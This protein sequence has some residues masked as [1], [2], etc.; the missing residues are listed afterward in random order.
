MIADYTIIG[1][2]VSSFGSLTHRYGHQAASLDR[3][4]ILHDGCIVGREATVIGEVHIY[5]YA[6]IASN[7]LVNFD[8]PAGSL[9]VGPKGSIRTN[10]YLVPPDPALVAS[11]QRAMPLPQ[12]Q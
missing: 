11:G 8:V 6:V 10:K 9:V 12:E 1:N 3:G 7:A 2:H 5:D 4:P